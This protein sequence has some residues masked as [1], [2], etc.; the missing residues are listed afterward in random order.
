MCVHPEVTG[1]TRVA[2]SDDQSH[3]EGQ[4]KSPI[5]SIP[6]SRL[7]AL[8]PVLGAQLP[9]LPPCLPVS[10]AKRSFPVQA[11]P[12]HPTRPAPSLVQRH[13]GPQP[14]AGWPEGGKGEDAHPA[15]VRQK[16]DTRPVPPSVGS[17]GDERQTSLRNTVP[18]SDRPR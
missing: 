18:A 17:A 14:S 4:G 16:K 6:P 15:L 3:S 8:C 12:T 11:L 9:S 1:H 2:V 7:Q 13:P 5:P 10:P